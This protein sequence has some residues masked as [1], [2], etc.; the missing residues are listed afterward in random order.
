M[1]PADDDEQSGTAKS[2][3]ASRT[4]VTGNYKQLVQV[5]EGN[6]KID[7]RTSSITDVPTSNH[8]EKME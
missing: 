7:G 3:A 5:A 2:T 4:I 1:T 8:A 6:E